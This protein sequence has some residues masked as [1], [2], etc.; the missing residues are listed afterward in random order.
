M[1][2]IKS[3]DCQPE[4]YRLL[5]EYIFM[6][7][8]ES[9]DILPG[10]SL[11][12]SLSISLSH[13]QLFENVPTSGSFYKR[14]NALSLSRARA[15]RFQLFDVIKAKQIAALWVAARKRNFSTVPIPFWRRDVSPS[16]RRPPPPSRAAHPP[17]LSPF[18]FYSFSVGA[19][20][21]RATFH[22][23]V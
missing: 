14:T 19:P 11:S 22:I 10:L 6:S 5:R 9:T 23:S 18:A 20:R 3:N 13:L 17:V 12:L 15:D 8:S 1:A 21:P 7:V 16:R 2:V 4:V